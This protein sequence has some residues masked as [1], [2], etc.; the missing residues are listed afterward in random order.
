MFRVVAWLSS[1]TVRVPARLRRGGEVVTE[2]RSA[3][4]P[5]FLKNNNYESFCSSFC[6]A[7]RKKERK[8]H[9]VN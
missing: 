3:R 8:K 5:F 7:C 1:T 9:E 4:L 6:L 2:G